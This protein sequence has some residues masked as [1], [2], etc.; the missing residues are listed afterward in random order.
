MNTPTHPKP[1]RRILHTSDVHMAF[2]GD[3]ACQG[4][5]AVVSLAIKSRADM[6]IIAGDLFDHNRVKE[7]LLQFVKGQ[8]WRLPIPV[9]VLPGNHDC[10][11]PGSVWE[12]DIWRD[13]RNLYVIHKVTGETLEMPHLGL[14]IWGRPIDTYYDVRPLKDMPQPTQNGWWNIAV[15][16]GLFVRS[17]PEFTRS[18]IITEQE[19]MG[20]GWDYVALGHLPVFDCICADPISYYSGSP[21]YGT[22]ALV[23]LAEDSGVRVTRCTL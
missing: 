6:L 2:A 7:D 19:L 10:L 15:A 23:D 3:K 20:S 4:F 14:S 13:C 11:V 1:S 5:E 17:L 9:V 12:R 16:H 8:F 18:Y 22:A 21:D